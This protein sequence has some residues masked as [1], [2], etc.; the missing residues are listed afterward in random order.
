MTEKRR[1][2]LK[3]VQKQKQIE[4]EAIEK[5][6]NHKLNIFFKNRNKSY[7]YQDRRMQI[8]QEIQEWKKIKILSHNN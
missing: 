8:P 5:H 3:K 1:K 7:E 6:K 4:I 2:N